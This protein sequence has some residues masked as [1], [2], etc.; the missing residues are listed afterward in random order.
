MKN[1]LELDI[2]KNAL[3]SALPYLCMWILSMV[4]SPISDA[5]VNNGYLRTVTARKLFNSIGLWGPMC[6]LL[7]VAYVPKGSTGLAVA[8]LTTAVGIN[9]ATYLGFQVNHIDLAPNHA[10]TMMGITNCAAN[11]M[12]FLAPLVVGFVLDDAVSFL[13]LFFY[14]YYSCHCDRHL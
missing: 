9:S 6:A 7:G 4:L 13:F 11:I 2:K 1:V 3:L 5:L 14:Y 8:L 10:G 12:S